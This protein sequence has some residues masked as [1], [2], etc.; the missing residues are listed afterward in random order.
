MNQCHTPFKSNNIVFS[1]IY[2]NIKLFLSKLP[3][4]K[5][6]FRFIFGRCLVLNFC[7]SSSNLQFV[8]KGLSE[9]PTLLIHQLETIKICWWFTLSFREVNIKNSRRPFF[10]FVL[11]CCTY[12]TDRPDKISL[13]CN[14]F[15]FVHMYIC[16]RMHGKPC[17]GCFHVQQPI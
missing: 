11:P 4:Q 14:F 17:L 1:L 10:F 12:L 9:F 15:L 2:Y 16:L 13:R 3:G 7:L 5:Q 8:T 6:T